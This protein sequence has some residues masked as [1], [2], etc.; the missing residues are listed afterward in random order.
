MGK[1]LFEQ[2]LSKYQRLINRALNSY[3][4]KNLKYYPEGKN[5]FIKKQYEL[6]KNACLSQGKR[7]R[8]I[9]TIMAYKA[10]G[11]KEE[12]KIIEPSLVFE[13]FHNY[14]LIHDDI[15]DEDKERRG[16]TTNHVILENFFKHQY[17]IIKRAPEILYH[18]APSRFGVIA[19]FINGK[20]LHTLSGLLITKLNISENRRLKGI[21]L[22]EKVSLY[23][24]IGQAIDLNQE[25]EK[26]ISYED[27]FKMVSYKTGQLLKT[28]I[29]WGCV[30][31]NT[32]RSQKSHLLKYTEEIADIFQIKDDL[33]DL[34]IGGKKGRMIGS[35]IKKGKKTLPIVYALNNCNKRDKG[36]LI[37]ELG[38]TKTS[39]KEMK[40]V[41]K[42][43]DESGSFDYCQ[44]MADRKISIAI[45]HL[46]KANPALQKESLLFFKEMAYFMWNRTK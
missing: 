13:L 42:I 16:V 22:L 7:L 14:T 8:P 41:I 2:T 24:N 5:H 40:R 33:L 21:E 32:T 37:K 34:G 39:P 1:S 30:L 43:L 4:N 26:I 27:Y 12:K 35:D 19:G 20:I 29:E 3:F 38:N 10:V 11:G 46:E 31:G 9:L 15:Y 17:K 45:K 6:I 23:D 28:A 18:D 44:K 36:F 25:Q